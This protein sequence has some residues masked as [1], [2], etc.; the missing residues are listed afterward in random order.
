MLYM[1]KIY[2]L[3]LQTTCYF[4]RKDDTTTGGGMLMVLQENTFAKNKICVYDPL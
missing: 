1:K 2:T 3:S 4:S